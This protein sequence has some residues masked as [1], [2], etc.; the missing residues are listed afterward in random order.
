MRGLGRANRLEAN[1]SIVEFH[2]WSETVKSQSE[3]GVIDVANLHN[4][5]EIARRETGKR[6]RC[7]GGY[8]FKPV[9]AHDGSL[10]T[11]KVLAEGKEARALVDI[12]CTATLIHSGCSNGCR[13][14]SSM[15]A[16]NKKEVVCRGVSAVMLE[17]YGRLKMAPWSSEGCIVL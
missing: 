17:I 5:W 3:Q 12:G 8:P 1:A 2:T 14:K 16:V 7:T 15:K 4:F 9:M 6:N 13:S 11:I 10:P